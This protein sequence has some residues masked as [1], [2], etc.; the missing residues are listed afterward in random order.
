[1]LLWLEQLQQYCYKRF[2]LKHLENCKLNVPHSTTLTI[3]HLSVE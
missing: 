2:Y 3:A 1:M